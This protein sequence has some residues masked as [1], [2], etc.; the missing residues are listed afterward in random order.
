MTNSER[1]KL[2]GIGISSGVAIGHVRLFHV[3]T[4]N[5]G[6]SVLIEKNIEPEVERFIEAVQN[7][8]RQIE[9]LGKRVGQRGEDEALTEVLT[10]HLLLLEDKMIYDRTINLIRNERYGAEYA[11]SCVVKEVEER[12]SA[13]PDLFRER[14]KDVED[15]C[16]RIMDNLRGIHTQ[17]LEHLEEEAIIVTKDL[18]PSDTASM[19]REKVLG[20]VTEVGGKTSH[21]AILA[22]AL[23]IPAIVGVRGIT[24][25]IVEDDLAILD[26]DDGV[27]II[28]PSEEDL[29][30]Y[31]KKQ[32]LYHVRQSRLFE[33]SQLTPVTLDGHVIE[34]LANIEFASEVDTITKYGAGGVGLYRTEYLFLNRRG[35]PSEEEQYQ[36]YLKVAEKLAPDPVTI[37]TFD[38]GGDKFV[39]PLEASM[40]LNPFLGCRAIRFCLENQPIFRTQL[41]AILR[42]G[43]SKNIQI[44]YPLISGYSE[45]KAANELLASLKEELR[46]DGVEFN[47]NIA[48]GAMIEVPSAVIQ[49]RDLAQDL[50]FFSIGTND[51][52]QYTLAVDRGN[53]KIAHLYQPLHPAVLR[54][55]STIVEVGREFGIPVDVCGEMAG[56]PI[57]AI[58]LL[59][60]GI[61]R[62]SMAPHVIPTIRN[63]VRSVPLD[64]LHRLGSQLLEM[65]TVEDAKRL[66]AEQLPNLIPEQEEIIGT[67]EG[68]LAPPE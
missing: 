26:S 35:V 61:E 52:I 68:F 11:L 23:E 1:I 16:R 8:R 55:I 28:R 2:K 5:V 32:D 6:E 43:K 37:R 51:L 59:S 17:S 20:F 15:I 45:L 4:L 41:R 9:E 36:D 3:S 54:M 38:L 29:T 49:A 67:L 31:R 64:Q 27:I 14:F 18:A 57:S 47:E 22:R 21:T 46:Q 50:D 65:S 44:L 63:M 60:L 58:V 42:A 56:D 7:T 62:L 48:V 19:N 39:H 24:N 53:E 13:L 33:Q 30:A 34:L 25:G 66:V 40:E 10:M 12:Y